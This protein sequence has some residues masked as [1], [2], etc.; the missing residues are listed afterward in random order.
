ML[1]LRNSSQ[2]LQNVEQLFSICLFWEII[3][4]VNY[5]KLSNF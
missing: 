2:H 1:S 4:E 5:L 3:A